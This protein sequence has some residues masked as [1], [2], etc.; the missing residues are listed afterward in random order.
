MELDSVRLLKSLPK[1]DDPLWMKSLIDI[2]QIS[3]GAI[4]KFS[5]ER[6][7]PRKKI[8]YLEDLVGFRAHMSWQEDSSKESTRELCMQTEYTR[9]LDKAYRF[10]HEGYVQDLKCHLR[11]HMEDMVCVVARVLASMKKVF[12]HVTILACKS[13]CSINMAY[14]GLW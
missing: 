10:F 5:V 9:M 2:P 14:L 3:F 12:Y 8:N 6:K 4:F 13:S 11:S 7:V 1:P